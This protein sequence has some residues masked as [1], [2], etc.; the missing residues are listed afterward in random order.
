MALKDVGIQLRECPRSSVLKNLPA[1]AEDLG[2]I[3][4]LERYPEGENGNPL[5]CSWLG[6]P[7]DRAAYRATIHGVTKSDT[8]E[9]TCMQGCHGRGWA[10]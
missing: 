4:G 7:M 10:F 3:P 2:S 5:Q 6:N 9:H 1:N 8:T